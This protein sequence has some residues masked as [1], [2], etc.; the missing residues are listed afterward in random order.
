MVLT[1]SVHL[2]LNCP[3]TLVQETVLVFTTCWYRDALTHLPDMRNGFVYP[4]AGPGLGTRLPP[5][6]F[7]SSRLPAPSYQSLAGAGSLTAW[8]RPFSCAAAVRSHPSV[9]GK[10]V[11]RGEFLSIVEGDGVHEVADRL[12]ATHGSL[13]CSAGG[14][15]RQLGDFG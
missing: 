13:L 1:A 4:M 15:T 11:M 9:S 2:S 8:R 10:P 5:E 12:E 6:P 7:D 3:S 14:R